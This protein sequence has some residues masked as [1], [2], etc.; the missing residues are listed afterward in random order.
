M[1]KSGDTLRTPTDFDNALFFALPI[2]IWQQGEIIDY[3]GTITKHTEEAV[4][5]NDE[6]YLKATCEF[7]V[8]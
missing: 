1:F 5:I 8:R 2:I 4:F 7:K 3:G 6:L